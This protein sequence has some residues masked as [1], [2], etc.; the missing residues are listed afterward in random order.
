MTT[1]EKL[2]PWWHPNPIHNDKCSMWL[3][4]EF[5]L[6]QQIRS[7][8]HHAFSYTGTRVLAGTRPLMRTR[9]NSPR[10]VMLMAPTT[11]RRIDS[12]HRSNTI[13]C[14][15]QPP[16]GTVRNITYYTKIHAGTILCLYLVP[17]TR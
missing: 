1:F 8:R 6:P 15:I 9:E 5:F 17:G 2:L 13:V 4:C 14:I 7:R 3:G 11:D 10:M 12:Q 16:I